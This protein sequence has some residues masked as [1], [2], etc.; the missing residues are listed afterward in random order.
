MFDD[1]RTIVTRSRFA[2][3]QDAIGVLAIGVMMT[4]ALHLPSLI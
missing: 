4:V 3:I 2:L 1:L